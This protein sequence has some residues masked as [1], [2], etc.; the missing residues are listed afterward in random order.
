MA[1]EQAAK[2]VSFVPVVYIPPQSIPRAV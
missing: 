2:G 1:Q